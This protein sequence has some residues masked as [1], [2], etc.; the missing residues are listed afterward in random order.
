MS[1][2]IEQA[3]SIMRRDWISAE[4]PSDEEAPVAE[5]DDN[6]NT[7]NLSVGLPGYVWWVYVRSTVRDLR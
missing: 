7:S 2:M 6:N 5:N 4:S 1:I 3:T